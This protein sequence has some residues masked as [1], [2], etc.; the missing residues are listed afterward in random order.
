MSLRPEP[1]SP[2]RSA[3][4]E[5]AAAEP[6]G[7][8]EGLAALF[9]AEEAHLVRFACGITRRRDTAEEL[10]QEAFLRLH[11][12]WETV[13]NPRAWL[14]RCVRNLALNALRDTAREIPSAAPPERG[15]PAP[16]APEELARFEACGALRM[17]VAGLPETDRQ[18]VELRYIQHLSY[19]EIARATGLTTG[20]V[21]FKL[22]HILKTL[23]AGLRELGITSPLG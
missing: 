7:R 11:R 5:A 3:L 10:V 18:V 9:E 2:P 12:E 16:A 4:S 20:N 15:D 22:H 8:A 21:G 13:E 19:A 1:S 14:F 17:L 23:A 6:P